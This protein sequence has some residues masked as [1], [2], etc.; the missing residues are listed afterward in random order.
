PPARVVLRRSSTGGSY[1]RRRDTGSRPESAAKAITRA[2][3]YSGLPWSLSQ[4]P[5]QELAA[6]RGGD[7]QPPMFRRVYA[8]QTH[9]RL[10]AP[11]LHHVE[12]EVPGILERTDRVVSR[13]VGH[14]D[15]KAAGRID[16]GLPDDD[17]HG[18][19]VQLRRKVAVPCRPICARDSPADDVDSRR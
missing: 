6:V 1:S 3:S 12:G 15:S 10:A 9:A 4:G 19:A 5:E 14:R 8:M 18:E 2:A 17:R 16:N 11:L 13:E 7:G